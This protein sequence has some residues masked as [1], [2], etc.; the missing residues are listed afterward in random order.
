[1]TENVSIIFIIN[2]K[3]KFV[4]ELNKNE[5]LSEIR[6]LLYEKIPN[7]SIFILSDGCEI[8]KKDENEYQLSEIIEEGK[9]YIKSKSTYITSFSSKKVPIQGSKLIYKKNNL[10]IYLYPQIELNEIEKEQAIVFILLG[11]TGSGKTLLLNTFINYVYG[12][13]FNDNF[14]YEIAHEDS[15]IPQTETRTSNVIVYNIKATNRFPPFQII[16]TPGFVHTKGFKQDMIT[17]SQIEKV[18]KEKINSLNAICFVT[19][20]SITRFTPVQLYILTSILD[21]FGEDV[22]ENFIAMLTFSDDGKPQV[23]EALED[24]HCI[25]SSIIPY[26]NKPWYYKFNN[27]A[28]F[29]TDIGEFNKFYFKFSMKN[30][31]E[32]TKTLIKLPRKNLTQTRQVLE[33]RIKIEKNGEILYKKLNEG[34]DKINN[35]KRILEIVSIIKRDVNIYKNLNKVDLDIKIQLLKRAKT[36][37]INLNNKSINI[38]SSIIESFNRLDEIALNKT[39]CRFSEDSV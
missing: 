22:K 17:F 35:I 9:V 7:D 31:E 23:M 4:E 2:K 37:L 33:E 13:E 39:V 10:D 21:L 6:K 8:D 1:M 34:M 32:F 28:T 16:D 36:D 5:K 15:G 25:F 30:M 18:F 27:S 19:M 20:S 3:S 24:P 12:I 38:Q 14:R 29:Y 26:L 11:Q